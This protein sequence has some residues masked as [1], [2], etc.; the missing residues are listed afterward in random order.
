MVTLVI[1]ALG[2]LSALALFDAVQAWRVAGLAADVVRARAAALHGLI[3]LRDPPDLP[4]LCLQPPHAAVRR[5]QSLGG[6]TRVELVWWA[7]MP[8]EIRA[9]VTGV[10][11]A[12]GRHRW[13]ARLRPD[14]LPSDPWVPGCPAAT[15]L[16][17][18]DSGWLMA[19][20]EG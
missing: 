13:L 16:R 9:Q 15:R 6:G 4:W 17:P 11:P 10:G 1:T 20:P 7:V 18:T 8:G 5:S 14:S 3:A 12:G 2:L 19:H